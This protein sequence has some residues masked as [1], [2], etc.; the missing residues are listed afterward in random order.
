MKM[1]EYIEK[2]E[3][4]LRNYENI[5]NIELLPIDNITREDIDNY[6]DALKKEQFL[7]SFC[8]QIKA[9]KSTLINALVFNDDI[10]PR[11]DSPHTAKITIL[12]YRETAEFEVEFFNINEWE[13]LKNG[14]DDYFKNY[15]EEYV[16]DSIKNGVFVDSVVKTNNFTKKVNDI[17]E[18]KDYVAAEGKFTPFVKQVIVYYPSEMLKHIDI[19]DTPGTN[20][21]NK[22]RSKVTKDWIHNSD[23]V[24]FVVYANRAFD[25][26]DISFIDDYL[27]GVPTNNRIMAINKIDIVDSIDELK[28]WV[29]ELKNSEDLKNRKILDDSSSM[30][31]VSSLGALINR[32]D[33]KGIEIS[34]NLQFYAEKCDEGGYLDSD[35]NKIEELTDLIEKKLIENKGSS[36][37]ATHKQKIESIFD[38]NIR[39]INLEIE[40]DRESIDNYSLNMEEISEKIKN[41][42]NQ[43]V[44][45]DNTIKEYSNDFEKERNNILL[46]FNDSLR[47]HKEGVVKNVKKE[48]NRFNEFP[49]LKNDVLWIVKNEVEKSQ[50]ELLKTVDKFSSKLTDSLKSHTSYLIKKLQKELV[51]RPNR[52]ALIV[53]EKTDL[54]IQDSIDKIS[55][56]L[57]S[58]VMQAKI[59]EV[60][61]FYQRW[62]TTETGLENA[63]SNIINEIQKIIDNIFKD[64]NSVKSSIKE[65]C[66]ESTNELIDSLQEEMAK[67]QNELEKIEK[68]SSNINEKILEKQNHINSL[69]IKME[70]IIKDK[71]DLNE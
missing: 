10:L 17:K 28:N 47:L 34:E 45:L 51:L 41:I 65:A 24:I 14:K 11:A 62:F 39:K 15:I 35:K 44:T 56:Q 9:G 63:K 40:S 4:L 5:L 57:D 26:S 13:E 22:L 46:E 58:K 49:Q 36:I 19:V 71:G 18:L 31:F 23:A 38:R 2:K 42:Q 67:I 48:I 21:P 12:K 8:G 1:N 32:M 60:T 64:L 54:I 55:S 30:V 69:K 50:T 25:K 52:M 29:N 37:I 66:K 16:N 68:D 43:R 53:N 59:K 33:E 6:S 3:A 20:D 70:K 27:L 7:V 61:Y